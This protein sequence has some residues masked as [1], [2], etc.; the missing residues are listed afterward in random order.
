MEPRKYKPNHQRSLAER[1]F[2]WL[3]DKLG[4]TSPPTYVDG[5]GVERNAQAD[6]KDS[7]LGQELSRMGNT[8]R[9]IGIFSLGVLAPGSAYIPL[10]VLNN[11]I[12]AIA[13]TDFVAS[14]RAKKLP[15]DIK[16]G[17]YL[18]AALTL[19]EGA[20]T[21]LAIGSA[22]KHSPNVVSK[23]NNYVQNKL[24][25]PDNIILHR[26][27]ALPKG[28]L[29]PKLYY[30]RTGDNVYEIP[31]T[32]KYVGSYDTAISSVPPNKLGRTIVEHYNVPK[33]KV[34]I[35]E[36]DVYPDGYVD[37]VASI[38]NKILPTAYSIAK[39]NKIPQNI[40]PYNWESMSNRLRTAL[41]IGA[42]SAGL[43]ILN[44]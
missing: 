44:K 35:L 15:K 12:G 39:S 21:G 8:A 27:I 17:N 33:S 40:P 31:D 14:D 37:L 43:V 26:A 6:L 25:G 20:L 28:T 41:G 32:Q 23:I 34:K 4:I 38:D 7:A 2:N 9:N 36:E 18:R 19:G 29:K 3:T 5:Y 13:A 24:N 22:V 16:D 42:G 11:G 30:Q 1:G 10:R